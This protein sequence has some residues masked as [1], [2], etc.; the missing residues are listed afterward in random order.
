LQVYDRVL[1]SHSVPTLV[2]LSTLVLMLYGFQA[3]LDLLRSQASRR[4]ALLFDSRIVGT[5]QATALRLPLMGVSRSA[6]QQPMRDVDTIRT[7]LAN[8]GPVA[9]L[10]LPWMPLYLAFVFLIHPSLGFL[11]LGGMVML[12]L[13]TYLTEMF[14][15]TAAMSAAQVDASRRAI[16]DANSRNA[17]ALHAMGIAERA[18]YRFECVNRQ[19]LLLQTR[20]SDV[21]SNLTAV[22]KFLRLVLQSGILGLGAY[23]TLRGEV[24]GGA[25]IAASITTSRALAPVE[26]VI[27][28]WRSFLAARQSL[29]RLRAILANAPSSAPRLSLPAPTQSLLIESLSVAVPG[30]EKPV[31]AQIN[32]ELKSGQALAVIG[33]SAAGKSSLARAVTGVW[34]P[35]AGSV[36]LDG[37]ELKDWSPTELGTHIGYLPQDVTLLEGSVAD[38]ISRLEEER[39]AAAIIAAARAAGVHEMILRLPDGYGTSVGPDGSALSAGQ[40]QRIALARALY[41]DPFL[42]VLDEPNSNLDSDGEAALTQAIKSV[43]DRGG[44]VLVIAHRPS[45]LTAA[46]RVAVID[47]G[48]LVAFGPKDEVLKKVLQPVRAAAG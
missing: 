25:I 6:A 2:A 47:G 15:R 43:R 38:N 24:S 22:S 45:A 30:T 36:R 8:G 46:D 26:M 11:C 10:D 13:L 44:I 12:V 9:F 31:L 33:P 27:G 5:V 35:W 3:V 28:Q 21:I 41:R 19:Y 4:A 48:R 23:L 18:A 32:L 16:A 1:S 14:S 7:F 40:R 29:G 37:A 20:A 34:P 42:V 39:D 17:E